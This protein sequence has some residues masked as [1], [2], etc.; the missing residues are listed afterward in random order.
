M[1]DANKSIKCDVENCKHNDC[2]NKYCTLNEVNITC[3]NK[4]NNANKKET[5]CN[6]FEKK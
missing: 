5:I 3:L 1:K 2:S 6:S 4:N